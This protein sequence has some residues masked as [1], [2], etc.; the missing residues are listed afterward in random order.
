[1]LVFVVIIFYATIITDQ[2]QKHPYIKEMHVA[3]IEKECEQVADEEITKACRRLENHT[4]EEIT[5]ACRRLENHTE[6]EITKACR[7]LEN[8]TEEE[9]TKACRR[10]ENHTEEEITKA[11]RRLENHTEEEITCSKLK[12][13][14]ANIVVGVFGWLRNRYPEAEN[15]AVW[16]NETLKDFQSEPIA[17]QN[18]YPTIFEQLWKRWSFTNTGALQQ[19]V[20]ETIEL[21]NNMDL[22]QIELSNLCNSIIESKKATK[23][24]LILE[25][26]DANKPRLVLKITAILL[27]NDIEVCLKKIF[28]TYR[29]YLTIHKIEPGCA[30]MQ[31]DGSIKPQLQSCISSSSK[32]IQLYAE[33]QI[34]VSK[35]RQHVIQEKNTKSYLPTHRPVPPINRQPIWLQHH[36]EK[37]KKAEIQSQTVRPKEH[38]FMVQRCYLHDRR[39]QVIKQK[40][41]EKRK[42]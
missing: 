26:Y 5:K 36:T 42:R 24:K 22:Y 18:D 27:F 33:M 6:E 37:H 13:D 20:K 32:K 8:H 25:P 3:Y 35:P 21:N 19:L 31:F 29:R 7:R 11:C 41:P 40:K 17:A 2:W 9:I 14:F 39:N 1:M 4:E 10:L 23:K 15:A 30:T 16:L 38:S 12:R 28:G 34:Y